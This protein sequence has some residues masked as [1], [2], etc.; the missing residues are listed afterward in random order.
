MLLNWM[1]SDIGDGTGL[2]RY[3]P[4]VHCIFFGGGRGA[5]IVPYQRDKS[6]REGA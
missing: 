6:A 3:S 2:Y 5:A 4:S 1:K